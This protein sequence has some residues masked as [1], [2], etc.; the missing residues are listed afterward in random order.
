M[1]ECLRRRGF[2]RSPKNETRVR[3]RSR[4]EGVGA[5]AIGRNRP[6]ATGGGRGPI[7]SSLASGPCLCYSGLSALRG[8]AL[9]QHPALEVIGEA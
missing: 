6:D 7:R 8:V 3:R 9:H 5:T 4:S 2:P 1:A